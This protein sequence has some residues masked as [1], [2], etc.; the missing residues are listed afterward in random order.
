VLRTI[1]IE[2]DVDGFHPLNI[3]RLAQKG[4]DPL[5]V[6]ATPDGVLY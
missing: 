4:R 3:G 2:K 1:S 5:F 6:P